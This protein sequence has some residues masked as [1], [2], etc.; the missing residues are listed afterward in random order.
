MRRESKKQL[1]PYSKY[2]NGKPFVSICCTT[3]N[4]GDYIKE[5]INGFL[6]QNTDFPLEILI[7][8][9]FSQDNTTEIIRE[10][11]LKYP[12]I[13]KPIYEQENKYARGLINPMC[14]LTSEAVGK[15]VAICEGD[16]YWTD[17]FK[18][19]K[20][21]DFL[22]ANPGIKMV[23]TA[24]VLSNDFTGEKHEVYTQINHDDQLHWRLLA[25]ELIIATCSVLMEREAMRKIELGY[26]EDFSGFPAGDIQLWFHF[27]REYRVG[28]IKEAACVYRKSRTGI[29]SAGDPLKRLIFLEEMSGL[30]SHLTKKYNA[31]E[32][33]TRKALLS[34]AKTILTESILSENSDKIK[35]YTKE[36]FNNNKLAVWLMKFLLAVKLRNHESVVRSR[37]AARRVVDETYKI[38][39]MGIFR[40][41]ASG[42]YYCL[43]KIASPLICR[44]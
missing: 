13:I 31:S 30:V 40:Y 9:D 37:E 21:V 43:R 17:P 38:H 19:Q 23:H 4:H 10:Y 7:R 33:W 14:M 44:P 11:A 16:D 24:Y 26:S 25:G 41:I 18:L 12:E 6:I 34:Y 5:A 32:Y 29:T 15:Y 3:Y 35:K 39:V 22:E 28:Y 1:I 42:L 27:A 20:Q 2:W 36:V 8:D